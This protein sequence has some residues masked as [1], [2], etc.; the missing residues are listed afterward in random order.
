[1][2]K[3]LRFVG[4]REKC[5]IFAISFNQIYLFMKHYLLLLL[6]FLS[7][8]GYA[9]TGRLFTGDN[10]L[11]SSFV[12]NVY[13]D[14]DG[15]M[16][17][18]TRN[19]L[20][21]YDGY[22]FKTLKREDKAYGLTSNYINVVYQSRKGMLYIGTNLTVQRRVNGRFVNINLRTNDNKLVSTYI[23]DLL[24]THEGTMLA[25]SSGYGIFRLEGNEA[26]PLG[27]LLR[28][29]NYVSHFIEDQRHRLWIVSEDQG[30]LCLDG[31]Q[32]RRYFTS[33]E[34]SSL[35]K[36]GDICEDHE[37]NIYMGIKGMGLWRQPKGSQKFEK[38]EATGNL[39]IIKVYVNRTGQVLLGCD[40]IGL[41][42]YHPQRDLLVANPY[43][44]SN[45]DLRKTKIQTIVEDQSGNTW[46]GM[47][48]KGIYMQPAARTAFGYMGPKLGAENRIGQNCV[49]S[50]LRDKKGNIWVGTDRDGL[51]LLDRNY[52]LIRHYTTTPGTILSMTEDRLGRIWVGSYQQ[53]C[54]WVTAKSADYH[55]VDLQMGE[56]ASVFGMTT[57]HKGNLWLASMGQGLVCVNFATN[58]IQH[59][60]MRPNAQYNRSINSIPNDYLNK[61]V[62]SHDG[63]R[64]YVAGT[65]G[66][67]CLNLKTGSWTDVFGSNCPNYYTFSR[68][69]LEDHSG[70]VW[71]G[72]NDGLFCFN[73][74]TREQRHFT[75]Q[76]GLPNNGVA[77]IGQDARGYLWVGTDH[78]LCCMTT[79]GKVLGCYYVNNGLQSNEFSDGAS[80]MSSDGRYMLLGGTG[81]ISWFD[82]ARKMDQ[83][84]SAKVMITGLNIGGQ[85]QNVNVKDS[86]INLS[87]EDN[88]FSIQLST[89]TYDVPDNITY[90]Y[91][92]NGENWVRLQPGMNEIM[93]SHLSPG[94]YRFRVKAMYNNIPS[95]IKSFTVEIDAPWYRSWL[96]YALYLLIVVGL[97]YLFYRY[98]R[99]KARDRMRL[100]EHIHAEEM[101]EAKLRFFM[102]ISHEIRTPMT[103][104][105]S[106]LLQLMKEDT[107]LH[108][109]GIYNTIKRNAERILHLIN[110]MMDLRKIDKGM[111]AMH[112]QET[113]MVG[114]IDDVYLLFKEQ[115]K[116]KNINF[117]FVHDM[118][119][120]PVWIDCRNFDKVL[121]NIISNAFKFTPAGGMIAI[122]L[123]KVGNEARIAV[124]DNGE[125]IPEDKMKRIF[126]RF[127]Q[128]SSKVNDENI[129][130]GIGLDLVRSIVELHYGNIEVHNLE[131]G[132]GCE[133]I[134]SLP[135]GNNHLKA[136]EMIA[137]A[138]M[139]EEVVSLSEEAEVASQAVEEAEET[140][141][142]VAPS[143]NEQMSNRKRQTIVIAE[144]DNEISQ[145]LQE[146]MGRDFNIIACS[147]GQEALE[148][149]LKK[150][151]SLV[152]TDL[153]MPVMNGNELCAKIKGNVNT[154]HIPVIMLTAKN[155]DEDRLEGLEVGADA[156]IVKPFNMDILRRTTLNMLHQRELL[157]N[158]FNGSQTQ[159]GK[160]KQI[161]LESPDEKLMERVMTV[162]SNN[163]SNPDLN[164][165]M[166]AQQVGISRVHLHRKMKELTNQTPHTFIRNTRLQQA[167]R[168]L[169]RGGQNITE[170]M[171]A[172]GFTNSASFSTMFK[173]LYGMSPR[174]YMNK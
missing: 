32:L 45:I 147:N 90:L 108:R 73:P 27:G 137:P 155:R 16:W 30:L 35:V 129:G 1:M 98:Q 50:V 118:P 149:V 167:A 51:Y 66:M 141:E 140:K 96:A 110:Q 104:I 68:V 24:E 152:I 94:T 160:I 86:C 145:Y 61:V 29:V 85:Q 82:T 5:S 161:A 63:Q 88:S 55:A 135:L 39:P 91:S 150:L 89:L 102:N 9:Q 53:G 84:W 146:E 21:R 165:D 83:P 143:L 78:G 131:N 125:K 144:D 97:V 7:L 43:Y 164:T 34:E 133:F 75:I 115:A 14:Q 62:V 49:A 172:C 123:N 112:M 124:S 156:Y 127:Y 40:G 153:M 95:Q 54:G 106:P 77:C 11:S 171:Y 19:G 8:S 105:V 74:K 170:V 103:L 72:T 23:T 120:L 10:Q 116:T 46:L 99:H 42:V 4:I 122:H 70:C 56:R 114:F 130:T 33:P 25:A 69:L 126:E 174:E 59:Y 17:F 132:G 138:E 3:Q 38:I 47:L 36:G 15:F 12:T 76:N 44:D 41:Y 67:S 162:I 113:D 87:F 101:G 139:E 28:K 31:K 6:T 158:K 169:Q 26:K 134:V 121:V 37:G 48:Q 58:D 2:K 81:G 13:Q 119:P 22:Q 93:F 65:V 79:E 142:K 57:D 100:Q 107:D 64:I 117:S 151:P 60:R 159:E 128:A 173:N 154:N 71:I 80:Y 166:I 168:L 111:L 92:I 20:N 148:A 18:A 136:E 52:N 163:I 109:Q 157:R